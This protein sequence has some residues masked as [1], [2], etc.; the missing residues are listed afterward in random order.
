MLGVLF[1]VQFVAR[2]P[3]VRQ[4]ATGYLAGLGSWDGVWYGGIVEDGYAYQPEQESSVAFFPGYPLI[5]TGVGMLTGAGSRMALVLTSHLALIG[6]FALIPVYEAARAGASR[7]TGLSFAALALALWPMGLFFRMAYTESVFVLLELLVLVA[8]VQQWPPWLAA[9]LAGAATGVRSVGIA[10]LLALLFDWWRSAPSWRSF[11][12]KVLVYSPLACWGILAF[13]L[14]QFSAFGD[15]LA[16]V[17]TQEHWA[18]RPDLPLWERTVSLVALEPLWSVYV[19]SSAAY[20]ARYDTLGN[21]IFSLHF[22]NPIYFVVTAMLVAW[23]AWTRTL[24]TSEWLLAAGLLLIPYV[25]HGYRAVFM[26]QA[27]YAA[28]VFPAYLVLGHAAAR[29]PPPV[30]ALVAAILGCKL[31]LFSALFAAW[32]RV[33]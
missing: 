31:A 24:T 6:V 9:A 32:Y 5:A 11:G 28:S 21:P 27:R 25:S 15:A 30:L 23:G 20:W 26:A 33:I 2:Q 3:H 17:R 4:D 7:T 22:W 16:F 19:P 1:G 29:M 8:I 12:V 18:I 10:L 14:Y 13:M